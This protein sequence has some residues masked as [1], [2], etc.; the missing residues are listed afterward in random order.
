M[1][2]PFSTKAEILAIYT[3]LL[4]TIK[5]GEITIFTDS[6]SA[7]NQFEQYK[8]EYSRS[9]KYKLNQKMVWSN[10][11]F[12]IGKWNLKVNLIKVKAHDGI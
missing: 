6:K 1:S 8:K 5:N 3:A 7:I 12:L 4:T 10:I 9:K 2:W 11:F